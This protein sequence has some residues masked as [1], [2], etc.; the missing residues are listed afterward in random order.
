[1]AT[2]FKKRVS[3]KPS[4]P[5]GTRPSLHNAQLLISSGVPSLDVLLGKG[6]HTINV[7]PLRQTFFSEHLCI[8][9][10]VRILTCCRWWV[11][12]WVSPTDRY[13][14]LIST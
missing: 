12:S 6:R 8:Y 4:H 14:S 7:G 10:D 11:G 13:A 3:S 1:M 9:H 5:H 2:S